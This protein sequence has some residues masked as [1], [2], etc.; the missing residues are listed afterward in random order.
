M[1]EV[2]VIHIKAGPWLPD[3]PALNNPGLVVAKGLL[4]MSRDSYACMP[5]FARRSNKLG[6]KMLGFFA[7]KD[8]NGNPY[9]F[10]A[11]STRILEIVG[12]DSL[13]V[14][15]SPTKPLLGNLDS[16]WS[17]VTYGERVIFSNGVDPIQS[18]TIN[19]DRRTKPLSSDPDAP[20][21]L[22]LAVVRDWLVAAN[23]RDAT[24]SSFPQRIQWSAID[25]PTRWPPPGSDDA[26][27]EQSDFQD[28]IGNGGAIQGIVGNLG[29]ADA[30]ILMERAIYRMTYVGP[31]AIFSFHQVEGARGAAAPG[32]IISVGA[33]VFYLGEDGFYQFDGTTSFPIG[34]ERIN[35]T[36]LREIDLIKINQM[37]ATVDPINSIVFW[38]YCSKG[39]RSG[40]PNRLLAYNWTIQNDDGSL[41]RWTLNDLDC[42]MLCRSLTNRMG[43]DSMDQYLNENATSRSV[44]SLPFSLDSRV[45]MGGQPLLSMIDTEGY[46]RVATAPG[47]VNAEIETGEFEAFPGYLTLLGRVVPQIDSYNIKVAVKSRNSQAQSLPTGVFTPPKNGQTCHRSLARY[48]RLTLAVT[49]GTFSYFNGLTVEVQ[50]GDA[51]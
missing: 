4:P 47:Q 9:N 25:N 5:G 22:Y 14:D 38:A 16:F 46:L 34:S 6:E 15:I 19:F 20:L 8:R 10:C 27:A 11:S 18:L 42:Q 32:S 39:N 23:L 1:R 43:L 31:P 50:K 13:W 35:K 3:L 41:G 24:G 37:S 28:L 21:A 17:I 44:D 26:I 29:T 12:Q 45:W 2:K 51:R 40:F 48:H 30:A 49:N 33:Q 7:T 36:I